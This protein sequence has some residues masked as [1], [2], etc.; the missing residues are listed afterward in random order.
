[1]LYTTKN[2]ENPD[3]ISLMRFKTFN[4]GSDLFE[5]FMIL[6]KR[7]SLLVQMHLFSAASWAADLP[8]DISCTSCFHFHA[9]KIYSIDSGIIR[10][11]TASLSSDHGR[12][13]E[14]II[15]LHLLRQGNDIYYFKNQFE[16]DFIVKNNNQIRQ[17]YQVCHQLTEENLTREKTGLNKAMELAGA[18]EGYFITFNQ[19]DEIDGIPVIPAWKW[20]LELV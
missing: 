20:C 10:A 11:N 1:M 2:L 8:D 16:C 14:N 12:I 9:K 17:A 15:F 4:S 13:L 7:C 6:V 19:E 18:K 5:G 3:I